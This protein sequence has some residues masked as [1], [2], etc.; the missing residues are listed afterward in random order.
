MNDATQTPRK[1]MQTAGKLLP[2]V[3]DRLF[4]LWLFGKTGP[5]LEKQFEIRRGTFEGAIRNAVE[6]MR[7][8]R[9]AAVITMRR[10][11]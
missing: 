7:D 2:S 4:D 11:A 10:A 8:P 3:E 9:P 6:R 5:Q 1:P